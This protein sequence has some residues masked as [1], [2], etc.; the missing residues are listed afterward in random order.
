MSVV[1]VKKTA[2]EITISADQQRTWGDGKDA[3]EKAKLF[4]EN[5]MVWGCCGTSDEIAMLKIFT[6][7]HTPKAANADGILD[8]LAEFGDW[9]RKKDS[10]A[11]VQ[12]HSILVYEQRIFCAFGLAVEEIEKFAALGSGMFCALAALELGQTTE[13]AVGIAKKFDLYCGGE[14]ETITIAL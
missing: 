10:S 2:K 1:A 3:R 11:R 6:K 8:F 14:T 9:M 12:N 13:K 7:N 4:Q 5:G